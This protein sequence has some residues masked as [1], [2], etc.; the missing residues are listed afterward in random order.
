MDIPRGRAFKRRRAVKRFFLAV[1]GMASVAAASVY[2]S[3]LEP[4]PP[5]IER[6]VLYVDSVRRETFIRRVRGPGRL[7]PKEQ[8][9]VSALSPGRVESILVRPGERVD[10]DTVLLVLSNPDLERQVRESELSLEAAEAAFRKLRVQLRN[11]F[12]NQKSG[13]ADVAAQYEQSRLEADLNHE[14]ESS[15]LVDGL[16]V[17]LA[18][19]RARN[20]E[21]RHGIE[22]DRLESLAE[23][24]QAEL[25]EQR[26]NIKSLQELVSHRRR[27]L[28]NLR[29]RAG[30][31]GQLQ[32]VTVDVGVAVTPGANLAL[33][34]RPDDLRAELRIPETQAADVALGQSV[35]VDTRN[36]VV[37]GQVVRLDPAAA[38]GQVQVDVELSEALPPGARPQLS[39]DGT[40]EIERV[41]D[42][43]VV[44]RPAYGQQFSTISLFKLNQQETLAVR[45]TIRLGKASVNT[46]QVLEGLSP[47]DQVILNDT[48]AFD[49]HDVVRVN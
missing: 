1:L 49:E 20:L 38:E 44:G 48:S 40:I 25:D 14:L 46:I 19:I 22:K 11:R 41:P 33:V 24:N 28:R 3:R 39:V 36:G 18:D 34:A 37:A 12:L 32:E 27:Q 6:S 42:A 2:I 23:S 31:S 29:V 16:R 17:K 21:T 10:P 47:G 45:T 43:L 7:V 9:L 5:S 15:G 8:I 26:A 30:I 13:L 4:A 35:Q